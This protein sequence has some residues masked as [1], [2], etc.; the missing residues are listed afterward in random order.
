VASEV[1]E[2]G[3]AVGEAED[4]LIHGGRRGD[5]IRQRREAILGS[6]HQPL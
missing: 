1:C 4:E 5:R 3:A 6:Q 2:G